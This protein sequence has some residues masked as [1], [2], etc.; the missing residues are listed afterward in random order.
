MAFLARTPRAIDRPRA[1]PPPGRVANRSRE[2]K[3][4]RNRA[5]TPRAAV[6]I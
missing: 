1:P 5:A 3:K 6:A 4:F 2:R